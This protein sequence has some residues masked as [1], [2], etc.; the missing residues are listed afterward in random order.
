M[1]WN[2]A[3]LKIL[4]LYILKYMWPIGSSRHSLNSN[5]HTFCVTKGSDHVL[6]IGALKKK[7]EKKKKEEKCNQYKL[8]EAMAIA[9]GLIIL[10]IYHW[11][12]RVE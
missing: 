8:K 12:V 7:K 2:S 1:F 9:I 5:Y 6:S 4:N 3:H 11:K 10:D